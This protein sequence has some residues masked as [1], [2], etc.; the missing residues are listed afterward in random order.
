[1]HLFFSTQNEDRLAT[2]PEDEA[3]HCVQV[4]RHQVGDQIHWVD[5]MGAFFSGRII[6]TGK[7]SCVLEIEHKEFPYQPNP[8]EVHIAIAPTK[9][10]A[11]FEWFL[12]KATEIGIGTI[13]PLHC[14]HSERKRIREDRLTKVLLS[15]MKQSIKAFLPKLNP[16]TPFDSF[17]KQTINY[18]HEKYIAHCHSSSLPDLKKRY[19][20]G[21]NAI[22]LI[23]PEGD[24]SQT[25]IERALE[26]GFAEVSLGPSRLR[27]ETAGIVA[28]HTINLLAR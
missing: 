12:E 22:V 23:G 5:G 16:L 21:K 14:E 11:R 25:E 7:K 2:L 1:M 10:I 27:T 4:L 19:T 3:R 24:F 26:G 15:A 9:N 20:S 8:I 13:T 28:C 17:I 6:E 18:S